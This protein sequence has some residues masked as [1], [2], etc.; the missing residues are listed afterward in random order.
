MKNNDK[1]FIGIY[2]LVLALFFAIITE[3]VIVTNKSKESVV[4][5]PVTEEFAGVPQS[6]GQF[7]DVDKIKDELKRSGV[8]PTEA[9]YWKEAPSN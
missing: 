8:V 1:I 6:G 9:R 3:N 5:V 4:T 7:V 2:V